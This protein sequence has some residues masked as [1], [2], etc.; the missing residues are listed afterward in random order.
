MDVERS[1]RSHIPSFASDAWRE[2]VAAS[3]VGQEQK[4]PVGAELGVQGEQFLGSAT[5]VSAGRPPDPRERD[6]ALPLHF[7]R[8]PEAT[9]LF[10]VRLVSCGACAHTSRQK[11]RV[12]SAAIVEALLQC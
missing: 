6:Q 11:P 2:V 9:V 10:V 8:T 7:G 12:T 1:L 3:L 5:Q 4:G